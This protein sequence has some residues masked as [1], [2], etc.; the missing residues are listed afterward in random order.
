MLSLDRTANHSHS[1]FHRT[2]FLLRNSDAIQEIEET[3]EETVIKQACLLGRLYRPGICQNRTIAASHSATARYQFLY[4]NLNQLF[5]L[6]TTSSRDECQIVLV[7]VVVGSV[8]LIALL[9]VR[10]S[11]RLSPGRVDAIVI[12]Q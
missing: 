7:V 4:Q 10:P 9:S 1:F 2:R 11:V 12:D 3:K 5:N 6:S 8:S